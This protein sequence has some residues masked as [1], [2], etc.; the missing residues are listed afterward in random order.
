MS[1]FR[2]D[3]KRAS[4]VLIID[5]E[6]QTYLSI[7]KDCIN[8][9][10]P[11]GKCFNE[12]SFKDCAVREMEEETNLKINKKDLKLM[13]KEK[14]G[15]FEVATYTTTEYTGNLYAEDGYRVGF[16]PLDYMLLTSN[17]I[18]LPYHEKLFK[19]IKRKK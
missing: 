3:D 10:I 7:F 1:Y 4:I 17:N 9:N 8:F 15:E 14:C 2:K 5:I 13:L 18:W 6:S 16:V 11:G 12:E 19:L